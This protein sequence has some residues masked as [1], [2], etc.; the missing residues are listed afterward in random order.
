MYNFGFGRTE[1]VVDVDTIEFRHLEN[2]LKGDGKYSSFLVGFQCS[3]A[4]MKFLMI[5]KCFIL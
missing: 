2:K 4:T 5:F 1:L 3:P